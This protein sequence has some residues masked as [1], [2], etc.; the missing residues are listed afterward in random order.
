MAKLPGGDLAPSHGA[1]EI[2]VM[3]ADGTNVVRL[4]DDPS[5]DFSPTWSP[6][7]RHIAFT[8]DRDGIQ[9][10]YVMNADGSGQIRLWYDGDSSG[11][12]WIA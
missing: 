3:D 4:T 8:T 2:F 5:G 7:E 1:R 10:V 11:P 12:S 9:A 6:D